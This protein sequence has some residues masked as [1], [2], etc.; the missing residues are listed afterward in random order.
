MSALLTNNSAAF[1]NSA[2]AASTFV[3]AAFASSF[4]ALLPFASTAA[5]AAFASSNCAFN[6][7]YF[8]LYA[9]ILFGVF[10]FVSAF[11]NESA[12]VFNLAFSSVVATSTKACFADSNAAFF[13]LTL[14]NASLTWATVASVL[15]ITFFAASIALIASCFAVL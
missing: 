8:V 6:C 14:F 9:S 5:A 12:S 15:A 2:F 7:S 1:V 10:P 11:T 13:S 3:W 4:V